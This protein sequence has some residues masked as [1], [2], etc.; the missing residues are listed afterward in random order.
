M[1][2][3][4]QGTLLIHSVSFFVITT[5]FS[6]VFLS[7]ISDPCQ[8]HVLFFHLLPGSQLVSFLFFSPA[9]CQLSHP[10]SLPLF[11]TQEDH[12]SVQRQRG[13]EWGEGVVSVF[14]S[15]QY[16]QSPKYQYAQLSVSNQTHENEEW[17]QTANL[18][19][20]ST[21]SIKYLL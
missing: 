2:K 20:I 9:P 10:P 18:R 7:F 17:S 13:R 12:Y 16:L 19:M 8:V 5:V 15:Q 21:M 6:L 1:L 14:Y 4:T 11:S 3:I